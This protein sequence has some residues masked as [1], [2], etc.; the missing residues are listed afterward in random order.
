MALFRRVRAGERP[1][2]PRDY[3]EFFRQLTAECWHPNWERRPPFEA[4]L[5]G[6]EEASQGEGRGEEGGEEIGEGGG[7]KD[8]GKELEEENKKIW[9]RECNE[10]LGEEQEML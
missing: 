10:M 3:P 4:I 7:G 9:R 1:P 2:I 8:K 6:L 5:R